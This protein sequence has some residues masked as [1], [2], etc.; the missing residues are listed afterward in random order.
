MWMCACAE[1]AKVL[2]CFECVD[3]CVLNL[4]RFYIVLNVDVYVL[5]LQRFY[6]G[7]NVDVCVC[8]Q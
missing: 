2:H 6:I 8:V 1:S 7:L 3:V 5:S 4:Q